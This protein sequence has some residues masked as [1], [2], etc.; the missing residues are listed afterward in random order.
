[1]QSLWPQDLKKLL[2]IGSVWPEPSSSAAGRRMLQIIKLFQE[3]HYQITF[4]SHANPSANAIDFPQYSIEQVQIELNSGTFDTFITALKPDIVLFDRFMTEEQYSWRVDDCCPQAM[5]ILDTE[6][7][8]CL[9][10]AREEAFKQGVEFQVDSLLKSESSLREISAILRCDLSLMISEYEMKILQDLFKVPK[11]IIYYLPFLLED[12]QEKSSYSFEQREDFVSIGNF[13]HKP[14][15]DSVRNLKENIWPLIHAELPNVKM[16]I[17]GAYT[18]PKA[19]QL[20]NEKEGFLIL[21][22]AK[23]AKTVVERARLCLSPLRFGAGLKGKLLEAM[24]CGTPSIT[25]NIGAEAMNGDYPWPGAI[26][27]DSKAFA[28]CAIENY[29]NK[30]MWQKKQVAGY[31]ILK[32]RFNKKVFAD[33]FYTSIQNLES[34]LDTHRLNNF[35]GRVLNHNSHRSTKFM[36]KWIEEKNQSKTKE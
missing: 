12:I 2:V 27:N 25:T 26:A 19:K 22:K 28:K 1:L 23:D 16:N 11:E 35:L 20:H 21:G 36:S 7:L 29:V 17:Y 32:N 5:R 13:L 14:N 10:Y 18:P 3:M 34:K 8:H 9:R 6:D 15:W 24:E 33:E 4:A 30:S 31:D